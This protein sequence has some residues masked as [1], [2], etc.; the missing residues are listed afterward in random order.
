MNHLS[1]VQSQQNSLLC[2]NILVID[3][4]FVC[5]IYQELTSLRELVYGLLPKSE[6]RRHLSSEEVELREQRKILVDGL[7]QLANIHQGG[8]F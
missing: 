1:I 2:R 8:I 3:K 6:M 7:N 4:I 5:V